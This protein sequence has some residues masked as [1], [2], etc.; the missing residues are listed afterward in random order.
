[1][2][3]RRL[4]DTDNQ[5][6]IVVFDPGSTHCAKKDYAFRLIE[7]ASESGA[8]A[9]KFQLFPNTREYTDNGNIPMPYDWFPELI[10]YAK[11]VKNP[12][13]VTASVFDFS[14]VELVNR[15]RPDFIKFAYSQQNKLE[16]IEGLL[17]IGAN[18]VVST[19]VMKRHHL[20]LDRKNLAV[21]FCQPIYP[22][23]WKTN[24]TGLFPDLFLG[25]SDHSLGIEESLNAVKAGARWI[26]KHITL[27][28]NDCLE[29]PDGK[30]ALKPDEAKLFVQRIR[31]CSHS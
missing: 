12:I 17:S 24:F 23:M 28:Y 20:P 30:F 1:V 29:C 27:P 5:S 15:Y 14:A 4:K 19:D 31:E 10:R 16:W 13:S 2:E 3:F 8:D 7:V 11:Q 9:I 26:E 22:T 18:V 25:F 21:L 6:C